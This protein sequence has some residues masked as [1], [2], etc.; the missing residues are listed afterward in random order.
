MTD[1]KSLASTVSALIG[2]GAR[3]SNQIAAIAVVLVAARFLG[4]SDFG[5]FA[6]ASAFVTYVRTML[7]CGPYEY[8]LKSPDPAD[9]GEC[10]LVNAGLSL[11]L[12]LGLV[13]L[14]LAAGLIFES[15]AVGRLL[16]IMAPSNLIAAFVA[17]QEAQILR[18]SRIRA[19]YAMT[20]CVELLS[21]AFAIVLLF[22]GAGLAAL[23]AQVYA[24]ILIA[25][26][27][28]LF[29][30]RIAI[31]RPRLPTLRRIAAWSAGRY[32]AVSISFVNQY[33][34][35]ILLGAFL[36]PAAA[37][38]YRAANRIVSAVTDLFAHP[39]GLFGTTLFSARAASG[40]SSSDLWPHLL[41]AT[42][43]LGWSVLAGLGAAAN[44]IVPLL[45]GPEWSAA[46]VLIPFFCIARAGQLVMSGTLPLLIAYDRNT[47]V[48]IIQAAT[49]AFLIAA[50]CIVARFGALPAAITSMAVSL[51]GTTAYLGLALRLQ[52][53]TER[54]LARNA[55]LVIL[56]ALATA[57]ASA[58]AQGALSDAG[59]NPIAIALLTTAA[60]ALA[61]GVFL[62]LFRARIVQSVAALSA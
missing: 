17:W 23:A 57:A 5:V 33:A 32:G 35:D 6:I 46:V 26:I 25:L 14:S 21:A 47:P 40:R 55:P 31:A 56:P 37:G 53:G 13:L 42:A 58:L 8:L 30:E 39:A 11:I 51:L 50:L 7:Y 48:L 61:W 43:F 60:G 52:P 27:G 2:I 28:Y 34:A 16:L 3:A 54:S 15:P 1:K 59:M 20:T 29:F 4:P 9:A 22:Q 19:Y 10:L 36:S 49:A 41:T 62:L 18:R 12:T 45:L 24:R 38:L 44:V